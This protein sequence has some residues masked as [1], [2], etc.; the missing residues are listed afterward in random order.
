MS[1]PTHA[2]AFDHIQTF[3]D[4]TH[5]QITIGE[6]PPIRRAAMAAQGKHVRVS[7]VGR[8]KE[9]VHELLQRLDAALD[10]F[11]ATGTTTDEVLPEI[12]RQR[13]LSAE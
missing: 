4:K 5:G 8:P 13:G 3:L 10:L 7:L 11:I 12:K 1:K 2:A 9:T 6:I